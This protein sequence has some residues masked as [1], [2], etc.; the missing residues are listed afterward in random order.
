MVSDFVVE[1]KCLK[2]WRN[3]GVWVY[4]D[5]NAP[6]KKKILNGLLMPCYQYTKPHLWLMTLL[7]KKTA[8]S[9]SSIKV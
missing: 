5:K 4:F 7:L 1:V 6:D 2:V 9:F 3:T 8:G